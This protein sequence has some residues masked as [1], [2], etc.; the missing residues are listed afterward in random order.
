M[1][2]KLYASLDDNMTLVENPA[3]TPTRVASIDTFGPRVFDTLQRSSSYASADYNFIVTR[4][5]S[6]AEDYIPNPIPIGLVAYI[7]LV[8]ICEKFG[9]DLREIFP[10]A[11]L[12]PTL[13]TDVAN[14]VTLPD[15]LN[16]A[17]AIPRL[18]M[19]ARRTF[20]SYID[21]QST[22]NQP[23][24]LDGLT[25]KIKE[26]VYKHREDAMRVALTPALFDM[27]PSRDVVSAVPS[28]VEDEAERLCVARTDE[29][30]RR[31]GILKARILKSPTMYVEEIWGM[32]TAMLEV[33][34]AS[35]VSS[36]MSNPNHE[37]IPG[38]I[39][40]E[41]ASPEE[42]ETEMTFATEEEILC[43]GQ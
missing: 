20:I 1:T 18:A 3:P 30:S 37:M 19:L 6:G 22:L 10:I 15:N 28:L 34:L 4:N 31:I 14:Q 17:A 33:F 25:A 41:L 40:L 21:A 35:Y 36:M 23:S 16:L 27:K 5:S 29:A 38:L 26:T 7:Q 43:L 39:P 11:N 32:N 8:K 24:V 12:G 42:M 9:V 13:I 2:R